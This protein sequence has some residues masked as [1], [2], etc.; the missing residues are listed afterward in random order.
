MER[1]SSFSTELMLHQTIYSEK[2]A[3]NLIRVLEL[4]PGSYGDPIVCHLRSLSLQDAED[5]YEGISYVWG[6]PGNTCSIWCNGVEH[7][8]T[9]S[10]AL[11]LRAVRHTS[12]PRTLWA[13]AICINQN[14][15]EEKG[16]QV[17]QMG[18][19]YEGAKRVLVYLGQ[20]DGGL[21]ADCFELFR[22]FNRFW[23]RRFHEHGELDKVSSN[24]GYPFDADPRGWK[25]VARLFTMPWFDRLWVIQEAG[26]AKDCIVLWGQAM[27]SF[28]E[29]VELVLWSHC[30]ADI[31]LPARSEAAMKWS[32]IFLKLQCSLGNSRTWRRSLPLCAWVNDSVASVPENTSFIEILRT[33]RALK[34]SNPRDH[35][36]GFLASP[37]A[38]VGG[39]RQQLVEPDYAR[40][41]EEVYFDTACALLRHPQEAPF[42]LGAIDH[43]SADHIAA[44]DGWPSWVPRWDRGHWTTPLAVPYNWYCAGGAREA[45]TM[46]VQPGK[47]LSIRCI[48]FDKLSW[49]SRPLLERDLGVDPQKWSDEFRDRRESPVEHLWEAI[50]RSCRHPDDQLE[51]RFMVAMCREYPS[52]QE[53]KAKG[54][55]LSL[56]RTDFTR[57]RRLMKK[58]AASQTRPDA[59]GRPARFANKLLVCNNRRLAHS[60]KGRMVLT[61]QFAEPGDMCGIVPGFSVPV[62]IRKS[63]DTNNYHLVGDCYVYG[64]M[65]GEILRD[66]HSDRTETIFSQVV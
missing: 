9:V 29:V 44:A 11:A 4:A 41:V 31:A 16:H 12:E 23:G 63:K 5:T 40:A 38:L 45:L 34:A 28:S 3:S 33:G 17:K 19:V 48:L 54:V 66:E 14:D 51:D 18:R 26:L 59:V 64:V 53:V 52:S 47:L 39:E 25:A 62:V 50:R 43:Q 20:D 37:L 56:L 22:D 58:V 60:E 6:D 27:M 42:F 7:S 15:A 21:A 35:V 10:L 49:L 36:Y 8:I 46:R 55:Q 24:P 32:D 2:L 13:D 61:P 30:R 65:R 1:S 57:Y